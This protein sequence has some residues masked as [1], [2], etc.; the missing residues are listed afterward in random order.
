M[1]GDQVLAH[2]YV[3]VY[4]ERGS[5]QFYTDEVRP[6]GRGELYA[7]FE[8]L[9]EKLAAEGLFAA[10]RKR[11]IP[12]L[13]HRLG[14]VTSPG[15]AALRDV[16]RVLSQRWPLVDVILFPTLVQGADAPPQIVAALEAADRYGRGGTLFDGSPLDVIL[17][18]RGGG[19]IEDLWAFN[20]E[21]VARAVAAT[22]TPVITG[23]GH[24]TDFT[25]VDFVADLRAPTPSAA[26]AAAVPDR[27]EQIDQ[28][29]RV[30]QGLVQEAAAMVSAH[31]EQLALAE[32]RLHR[33]SPARRID[34]DRQRL[35]DLETRLHRQM[36]RLLS[37]LGERLSFG[38]VRL[39]SLNPRGVLTRGYSIVQKAD[40]RVV[41]GPDEVVVGE[42]LTVVAER[43]EYPV[44]VAEK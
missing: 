14:V 23:V 32:A 27:W 4:P 7:A 29:R 18:V 33:A 3:G 40:G 19:S 38:R 20:D 42:R 34:L 30:E 39:E 15:A 28:L 11:P 5:Y 37:Q 35:D 13:P 26:A 12:A 36:N 9:K 22:E 44:E 6:A 1:E 24:E 21:G 17:L 16:L 41:T 2:G 8:A 43:G 10:E 31:Q 25:I